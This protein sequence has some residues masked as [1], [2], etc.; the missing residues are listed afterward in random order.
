MHIKVIAASALL[1]AGALLS[2]CGTVGHFE[3]SRIVMPPPP[4]PVVL[5]VSSPAVVLRAV[6]DARVFEVEPRNPETPSIGPEGGRAQARAVGRK[7]NGYGRAVGD[8]L[9][10]GQTVEQLIRPHIIA[11]FHQGGVRVIEESA[12][13]P[14]I[15]RV[16]ARIDQFWAWLHPSLM[17]H[18]NTQIRTTLSVE[19][20]APVST[21]GRSDNEGP[22]PHDRIWVRQYV[23]AL[24]DYRNNLAAQV[25]QPPFVAAPAP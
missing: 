12:A 23:R 8:V 17:I 25:N 6:T 14:E 7:R 3:R 4:V 21:M 13:T 9:V 19:G 2:G 16:D 5:D 18:H 10:R 11:A 22:I 15:P 1:L 24:E 20:A